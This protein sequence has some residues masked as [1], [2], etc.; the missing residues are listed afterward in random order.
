VNAP[1]QPRTLV[2]AEGSVTDSGD[3]LLASK[4]MVLKR[5]DAAVMDTM[6]FYLMQGPATPGR[7]QILHPRPASQH[8]G[9]EG[10]NS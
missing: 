8:C 10:L 5:H 3:F 1:S 7:R 2:Y 4:D 6:V 9:L